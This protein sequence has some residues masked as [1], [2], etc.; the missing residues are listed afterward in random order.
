MKKNLAVSVIMSFILLGIIFMANPVYATGNTECKWSGS[1]YESSNDC[2]NGETPETC[3]GLDEIECITYPCVPEFSGYA[4]IAA[5]IGAI[6]IPTFIYMLKHKR[7][8]KI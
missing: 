1:C 3:T 7:K 8:N 5:L 2:A 6:L 4:G